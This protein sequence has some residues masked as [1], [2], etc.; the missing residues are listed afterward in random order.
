MLFIVGCGVGIIMVGI[1]VA[2]TSSKILG[3]LGPHIQDSKDL[4]DEIREGSNDRKQAQAL[5]A[6]LIEETR[7]L[8]GAPGR[9]GI[10]EKRKNGTNNTE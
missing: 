10:E 3:R 7:R 4:V 8:Q 5:M 2:F 6:E 1:G 9:S